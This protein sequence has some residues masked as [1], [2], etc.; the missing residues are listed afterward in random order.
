M[1]LC[2]RKLIKKCKVFYHK[3]KTI[4]YVLYKVK[5][6]CSFHTSYFITWFMFINKTQTTNFK[7][8][9]SLSLLTNYFI[10]S[11]TCMGKYYILTSCLSRGVLVYTFWKVLQSSSL[12]VACA[13]PLVV[14]CLTKKSDMYNRPSSLG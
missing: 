8:H 3:Y 1:H 7:C 9:N 2:M 10:F 11:K 14:I 6:S 5:I 13:G 12:D 4:Q